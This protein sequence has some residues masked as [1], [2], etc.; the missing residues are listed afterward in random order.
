VGT[1]TLRPSSH[2]TSRMQLNS[3]DQHKPL[4]ENLNECPF[5]LFLTGVMEQQLLEG[6]IVM[7]TH[8]RSSITTPR[9]PQEQAGYSRMRLLSVARFE[10]L[11]TVDRHIL[12]SSSEWPLDLMRWSLPLAICSSHL[13][14]DANQPRCCNVFNINDA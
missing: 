7:N 14:S 2:Y 13:H 11:G 12:L 5:S 10:G 6:R 8:A 9:R 1:V 4:I 3:V